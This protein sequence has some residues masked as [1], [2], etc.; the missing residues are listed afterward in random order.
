MAKH[1]R[2]RKG[3]QCLHSMSDLDGL[4]QIAS[5]SS[6]W[7]LEVGRAAMSRRPKAEP[8]LIDAS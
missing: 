8:T 2:Q 6:A 4:Y 7:F 3:F 1:P 5:V